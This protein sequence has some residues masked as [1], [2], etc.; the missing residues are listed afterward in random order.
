MHPDTYLLELTERLVRN[1]FLP[2]PLLQALRRPRQRLVR[3][4]LEPKAFLQ[5]LEGAGLKNFPRPWQPTRENSSC[6]YFV[7]LLG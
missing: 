1:P 4:P 5:S 6:V 3:P 7:C 2:S